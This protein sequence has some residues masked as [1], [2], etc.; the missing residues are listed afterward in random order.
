[1][2]TLTA[3]IVIGSIITFLSLRGGEEEE[4]VHMANGIKIGEVTAGSAIIWTRLTL[5]PERGDDEARRVP[6]AMGEVR[7]TYRPGKDGAP[8]ES[9]GWAPVDAERDFTLQFELSGLQPGTTYSVI[10]E[11]R[12]VGILHIHDILRVG[13][14][15]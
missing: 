11:G 13:I 8:Q 3:L 7:V 5:H 4:S 14:R 2:R 10:A 9:A 1:M 12:P 6:G 15:S